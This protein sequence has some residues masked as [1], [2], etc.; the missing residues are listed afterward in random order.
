M[1]STLA[2]LREWMPRQRWYAG[3]EHAPV[4]RLVAEWNLGGSPDAR[5]QV[6]LV[7]DSGG[8]E[9]VLYQVPVVWRPRDATGA[10]IGHPH[11]L[12]LT[13]G[14][15]DPAF[16][17]IAYTWVTRGGRVG[18]AD[19]P[20]TAEPVAARVH[21]ASRARARVLEGEQSNTSLILRP[22]G[23]GRPVICKIFRQVHAGLNPDIE[24]Q[25]ALY[26]AG[27]RSVPPVV[28]A[29]SAVWRDPRDDGHVVAGSLA[30]AQEFFP[31]VEDAWRVALRAAAAGHPF[32]ER[33][34]QLGRTVAD[35]H[36][37]LARL[38]PTRA[39]TEQ[40]R[41]RTAAGWR[42]RVDAAL[43]S[44][45]DVHA[46]LD[47]IQRVYERA[48]ARE[49]PH[50]QRVH[51]DLH[52]GQVLDVPGRGWVLLDFEGEPL[53]PIAERHAPDLAVR[54][55]AG[56]LR[57]FAYAADS[58]PAGTTTDVHVWAA[59]ARA[60]FLA[61]YAERHGGPPDDALLRAFELDKALYET[62]YEARNRPDWV[63]IP[64][65]AVQRI[66]RG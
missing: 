56:M 47:G 28:A 40:D 49:W 33:A 9:P 6:L 32:G 57:S 3:K 23:R 15:H 44:V 62:V 45:P 18:G 12:A 60:G 20:L 48:L 21:G 1:D 4:L 65:A 52:L 38:F 29:V 37:M 16:H 19:G 10:L 24:L 25:T 61:G 55:V 53:R 51:G 34:A 46:A 43:A 50:L 2:C 66:S 54:D 36:T 27:A 64:L 63:H 17:D 30:F 58:V 26:D 41:A 8:A 11:G 22:T 14:T 31:D 13:D 42:A 39:A 59:D 7:A 35:T 5:V